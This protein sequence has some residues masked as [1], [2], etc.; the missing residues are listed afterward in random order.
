MD[1]LTWV[2]LIVGLVIVGMLLQYFFGTRVALR[3]HE[4][5][6]AER[7]FIASAKEE[8]L[9]LAQKAQ[10]VISDLKPHA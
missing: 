8:Y 1:L 4:A 3:A 2:V 9:L 10:K 7:K 6:E 5:L